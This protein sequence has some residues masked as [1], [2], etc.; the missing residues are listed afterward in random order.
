MKS[1]YIGIP[2]M[3]C[4]L[5]S[6]CTHEYVTPVENTWRIDVSL[7]FT[8]PE[9]WP[10]GQQMRVGVFD[11]D[12][13]RQAV[14]SVQVSRPENN[15]TT[16]SVGHVPEGQY[17]LQ[18]YLTENGVYKVM[19]ADLGEVSLTE[20]A[21][22]ESSPLTLLTYSR[23]QRQVFNNCQLCHGGSSGELAANLN[24]TEGNSYGS[25]VGVTAV[26]NPAMIRV[27]AGSANFSYLLKVLQKEIDFDHPASSSATASDRQ[28]VIDWINE[29]AKNN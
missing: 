10:D 5:L 7:T 11:E 28:L 22:I 29:G 23:V 24:L 9:F 26:K 3:I 21:S 4:I 14:G 2:V 13:A 25:L 16:V 27:R 6:A 17:R 18:L 12:N 20:N 1:L 15:S 19:V 8:D